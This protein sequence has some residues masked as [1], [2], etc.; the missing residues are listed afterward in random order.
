LLTS[1]AV[2]L[3]IEILFFPYTNTNNNV[4]L[5]EV[6]A[7]ATTTDTVQY[8]EPIWGGFQRVVVG[9][10]DVNN[11]VSA[12]YID[13][14]KK[15]LIDGQPYYVNLVPWTAGYNDMRNYKLYAIQL[16]NLAKAG[17]K[18][19]YFGYSILFPSGGANI[20]YSQVFGGFLLI[21][22]LVYAI[23]SHRRNKEYPTAI[24]ETTDKPNAQN[25]TT[26]LQSDGQQHTKY[27][28]LV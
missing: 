6:I 24:N 27:Q 13:L 17:R 23:R 26:G 3:D 25:E 14:A 7:T 22:A 15:V 4:R 5:S 16:T 28:A 11:G 18:V 20:T 9:T 1:K 21:L 19:A 8:V 2:G 12:V 10:T